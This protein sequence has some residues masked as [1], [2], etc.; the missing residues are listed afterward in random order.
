MDHHEDVEEWIRTPQRILYFSIQE[1]LSG[2]YR[3]GSDSGIVEFGNL[4]MG[5]R[6]GSDDPRWG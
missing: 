2:S 5:G 1:V 6:R 3:A 4:W